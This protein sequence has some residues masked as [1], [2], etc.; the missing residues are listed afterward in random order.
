[1]IW[2]MLWNCLSLSFSAGVKLKSPEHDGIK[3]K[4]KILDFGEDFFSD[5]MNK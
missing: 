1:M 5:I 4:V 2:L 3:K